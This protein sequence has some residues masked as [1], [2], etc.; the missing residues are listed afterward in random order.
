MIAKTITLIGVAL[1][2]LRM[3]AVS[4]DSLA[5]LS[6]RPRCA[7]QIRGRVE[8]AALAVGRYGLRVCD[9]AALLCKHPNSV[10]NWLNNGLR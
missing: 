2:I 5:E 3:G 4:G 1:H 9:V 6:S 7:G 8:F 10:T